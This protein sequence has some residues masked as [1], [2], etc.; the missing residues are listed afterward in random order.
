LTY[1]AHE[2]TGD[3]YITEGRRKME[4]RR[5]VALIAS[6]LGKDMQQRMQHGVEVPYRHQHGLLWRGQLQYSAIFQQSARNFR[7]G[8]PHTPFGLCEHSIQQLQ[9][10]CSIRHDSVIV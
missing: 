10:R 1:L 2:K 6:V 7:H 3:V 5:A 9:Q 4:G 8:N